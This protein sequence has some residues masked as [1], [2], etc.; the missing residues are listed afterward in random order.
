MHNGIESIDHPVIAAR[1]LDAARATFERLG[2]TVPPRGSHVEW[3][4][5][6]LCIM[7][8][9][10]YIEIRAIIDASR[11]TMHLDEHLDAFGEGLMGIAFS[12]ADVERSHGEMLQHGIDAGEV[13]TLTRNFE[14][15]ERWTHPSFRLCVPGADDI[16]GLMHVVVLQHLTPE[17]IRE[18]GFLTHANGCIGVNSIAGM[19]QDIERVSS[20]L[21]RLLGDRAVTAHQHGVTARLPT[22]QRIDLLLPQDYER[23]YARIVGTGEQDGPRL[24]ALTLRVRRLDVIAKLLQA[25]G[26]TSAEPSAAQIRV[27]P[28]DA[29]GTTL[30]FTE[31]AAS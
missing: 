3:G 23:I 26:V 27:A 1:N 7:F 5:G 19:I 17:L 22:G 13:S 24:G 18:P 29:C 14:H 21:R 6:N 2:F 20:R 15:P 9:D 12:T 31:S 10:D 8:P 25:N 28:E 11:F 16:H 30:H 4:T